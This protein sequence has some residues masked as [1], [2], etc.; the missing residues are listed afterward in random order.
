MKHQAILQMIMIASLFGTT[1]APCVETAVARERNEVTVGT[2][3]AFHA[4]IKTTRPGD[5][6]ILKNGR[7]NDVE[8]IAEANGT[9]ES[10]VTIRAETP[11]GV[12]ISG[13]S[14]LRI[15]GSH[16]VVGGLRFEQ[17][18]HR[19]ALIE[20]RRDSKRAADRCRL[21]DCE[22]VNCAPPDPVGI[23]QRPAGFKYVSIYGRGNSVDHC[24]LQGKTNE[25]A[26]LVVWLDNQQESWGEHSIQHNHFG[27]RP[28]LGRNGG[29]TIRIGDSS[30]A[31]RS[32]KTIVDQNV[33]EECNG[34]GEIISNKSCDN[35]YRRNVFLR[36]SG[37]LTLRH[38]HRGLVEGNMFLGQKARGSGGVRIV[39]SDH[40]VIN[41]Y[42]ER[43]EGDDYRSALCVMN[44]ILDTPA[45]G[46]DRVDRAI[47]AH[48]TFYDCKR[49]LLIGR[50]NDAESQLPPT[51]CLFANNV[52]VSR[53]GPMID[54]R[55]DTAGVRW[56]GNQFYG[57]GELGI[58]P[59]EGV[60][61]LD[62]PPLRQE[63]GRWT[64]FAA[65]PLVDAGT[66]F[67][68]IP[69]RDLLGRPRDGT[70]DVGCDEWPLE[71]ERSVDVG[72]SWLPASL[73]PK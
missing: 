33:F 44:G 59:R 36:C 17:A 45:N 60:R 62:E 16:V 30:T 49:T 39:G 28:P 2:A 3:D 21:T 48:N 20:F 23:D 8:L 54:L 32:A 4:E 22:I 43:L 63:S 38:G 67:D 55:S 18:W 9:L 41:N 57:K 7:W 50:E 27:P 15:A 31:H 35:V 46:Y 72:P 70:P 64:L 53:R 73:F 14:R 40:V 66:V 12:T 10:P 1:V 34:E 24:R 51:G 37:A 25:G 69:Q 11:G 61:R 5:V 52:L 56:M 6:I 68:G 29:E 47:V 71:D 19:S 42:F 65:S 13:Y 26:T 58:E